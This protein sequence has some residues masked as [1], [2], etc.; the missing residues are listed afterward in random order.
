MTDHSALRYEVT[1]R[2]YGAL[3]TTF[4]KK[5]GWIEK[6][7]V[8]QAP[9]HAKTLPTF[10]PRELDDPS[11]S[12]DPPS[13]P[14]PTT[15]APT[16]L[17]PRDEEGEFASNRR[18]NWARLIARTWLVDPEICS[19]CGERMRVVAAI[20][21]PAQDDVIERILKSRGDWDP[22]WMRPRKIRG[23]PPPIPG[24]PTSE[25]RSGHSPEE[26]WPEEIDPPHPE[27]DLDPTFEDGRDG[28]RW[29]EDAGGS[30][31][32]AKF[33][34]SPRA[35]PPWSGETLRLL[36]SVPLE[37]LIRAPTRSPPG[38]TGLQTAFFQVQEG[39]SDG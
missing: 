5:A 28:W 26:D 27:F 32:P 15:T 12:I 30:H 3:S 35:S 11:L 14:A 39:T 22:P 18:R 16:V 25:K 1:I 23:P 10:Q 33:A 17:P 13:P 6:P 21:S 36:R 34:A 37:I 20:S 38:A 9:P 29:T 7:P 8:Q 2:S 4:R 24:T 19:S 31:A